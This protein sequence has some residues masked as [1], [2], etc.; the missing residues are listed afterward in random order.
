M[1]NPQSTVQLEQVAAQ[2]VPQPMAEKVPEGLGGWLMWPIIGLF[3]M[4]YKMVTMM[5]QEIS[6]VETVWPLATN[7]ASDF[8]VPGFSTAY[9]L[10]QTSYGVL[11]AL[12]LWTFIAAIKRKKRTKWWFIITMLSYTLMVFVA[13]F[14]FPYVFGME[15]NYSNIITVINGSFYCVLWIPYFLVSSRVKNTFIG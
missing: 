5:I 1:E 11:I 8:Y 15:I 10:L 9:Y 3:Y 6:Q 14:V 13:R 2:V 12:L 4:L 7:V